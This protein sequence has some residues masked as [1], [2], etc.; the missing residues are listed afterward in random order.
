MSGNPA[1]PPASPRASAPASAPSLLSLTHFNTTRFT[2]IPPQYDATAHSP[3]DE[4]CTT[5]PLAR[6]LVRGAAFGAVALVL[7]VALL[8]TC[9]AVGSESYRYYPARSPVSPS[10]SRRS[11]AA[12]GGGAASGSGGKLTPGFVANITAGV[13]VMATALDH[14]THVSTALKTHSSASDVPYWLTAAQDQVTTCLDGF[15]EFSPS[16]L[17]TPVG[18]SLQ[19]RLKACGNGRSM[20]VFLTAAQDQVTTCL[21]CFREFSPATLSTPVGKSL[22]VRFNALKARSSARGMR[23]SLVWLAAAQDQ[24]KEG[25][26]AWLTAAQD[27]VTTC[28]DGFREFSPSTLNTPAG[29][30]LQVRLNALKAC[31]NA[32]SLLVWLAATQD[33]V[34][35]CLDG[36]REFSPATLS[37]PAGIS[38]QVS[39]QCVQ[40]RTRRASLAGSGTGPV[41]FTV[42]LGFPRLPATPGPPSQL[43]A[44]APAS[45]WTGRLAWGSAGFV[46]ALIA[47][48]ATCHA[49]DNY[50]ILRHPAF[51]AD[52]PDPRY[53]VEQLRDVRRKLGAL[54][55]PTS[56]LAPG[57][58]AN[59]T[60]GMQRI[61]ARVSLIRKN[62]GTANMTGA[63]TTDCLDL[64]TNAFYH[65]A[66]AAAALKARSDDKDVPFWVTAARDQLVT[67]LDGIWEFSLDTYKSHA[68][69][70]LT[71]LGK[72][73]K[74]SFDNAIALALHSAAGSARKFPLRRETLE[75]GSPG[76]PPSWVEAGMY[77]RIRELQARMQGDHADAEAWAERGRKL[78]LAKV[79]KLKPN[80]VV[81]KNEKYKKISDALK[82]APKTGL[83]VVYI[84]AGVYREKVLVNREGVVLV[85]DGATKTIITGKDSVAGGF[86]TYNTATVSVKKN[87]F[88]AAG[89]KFE[90]TAGIQGH[91]AVALMIDADKAVVYDCSFTGYQDTLYTHSGRQ[92]Y[93]NCF[94]SG[95]TDFIFGNAAAVIDN[96]TIEMRAGK[97]N[98]PITASGRETETPTG[99]VIRYSFV[100]AEKGVTNN[101]GYLG[102]PW[103]KC[104]RT[105][106]I[107]TFL[108]Q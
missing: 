4:P 23:W 57:L 13:K 51:C 21:D 8:A 33:Q 2:Q 66:K 67:C 64:T 87:Y 11:L 50:Y 9:H 27:Q 76:E 85:G 38:F 81:G 28:M 41:V 55:A 42:H 17:A 31:S 70:S 6:L 73:L 18:K 22:Q 92:Y 78:Q 79:K 84:K 61:L 3:H 47:V 1:S 45:A 44:M 103:K 59:I 56:E 14:L 54:P 48:L 91:Q 34:T 39:S 96:C 25:F 62:R 98:I 101:S 7:L 58:V 86:T 95:I 63:V 65:L 89:I 32:R 36:F 94:I 72:N 35:K 43:Q 100:T 93:R 16:T 10:F 29:K 107:N 24:P 69:K 75:G 90:N 80:A 77:E 105:V 37:T 12:G 53:C 106:Y 15:R 99:I 82:A 60:A 52:T 20:L 83:Y 74:K 88:Q 40:K 104:A 26:T 19:V 108:A 68:G 49:V 5:P 102:R 97:S 30:S 46:L 71:S